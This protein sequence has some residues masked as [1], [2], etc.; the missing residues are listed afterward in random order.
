M[1]YVYEEPQGVCLAIKK[2]HWLLGFEF[3]AYIWRNLLIFSKY[4]ILTCNG[5]AIII[6]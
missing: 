1:Q 6:C 3:K 5:G 4:T 2:Y